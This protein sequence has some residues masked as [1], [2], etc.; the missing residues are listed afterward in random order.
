MFFGYNINDFL[1]LEIWEIISMNY[2]DIFFCC[3]LFISFILLR[4]AET[5]F[6][7][8]CERLRRETGQN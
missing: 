5:D 3:W 7:R 8:D 4:K 2:F 1:N 6:E